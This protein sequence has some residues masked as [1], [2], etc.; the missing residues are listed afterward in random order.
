[1][2]NVRGAVLMQNTT[3]VILVSRISSFKANV[4][5]NGFNPSLQ[6]TL[7]DAGIL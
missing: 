3:D 2:D 5:P 6:E 1:V 7:V 4:I